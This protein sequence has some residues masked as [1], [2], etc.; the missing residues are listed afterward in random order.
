[1]RA[2]YSSIIW[3]MYMGEIFQDVVKAWAWAGTWTRAAPSQ[4]SECLWHGSVFSLNSRMK[5]SL[6]TTAPSHSHSLLGGATSSPRLQLH[7]VSHRSAALRGLQTSPA[8]SLTQVS[9]LLPEVSDSE[10]SST[11]KQ[12]NRDSNLPP[13]SARNWREARTQS[14]PEA[15]TRRGE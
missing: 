14:T 4:E 5:T 8:I 11:S 13:W 2:F 10:A 6:R 15:Y 12:N 9:M 7:G 1:M 3:W